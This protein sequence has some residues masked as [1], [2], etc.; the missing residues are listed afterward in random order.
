MGKLNLSTWGKRIA[1]QGGIVV[2]FIMAFEV[3][4]MI[5][6]F[7]FFFYSVFNP[8]FEWLNT[9]AVTRWMT[10]FFLPHMIL[11]PSPPLK[12]IRILGSLFFL[13]GS[14]T[15]FICA[16]QVY[17]GKIF[18]WGIAQKG[19]YR[20]IRHPQYTALGMWGIGMAILWPRFI[21]LVTL[22]IMFILYYFLAKDEE[23]RMIH[24]FGNAY[25]DYMKKTGMFLP[26]WRNNPPSFQ[27]PAPQG[28]NLLILS[29][30]VLA[31][32][33]SGF[34]LRQFT[35][36]S[37]PIASYNNMTLVSIL[38]EDKQSEETILTVSQQS[39][40]PFLQENKSY[41]GYVMPVD[42]IMQGMIANTGAEH[43]LYKQ[44]HTFQLIT[45][46]VLHPFDHL[47]RSPAA[48]MAKMKHMSPEMA[49]RHHCPLGIHN[50]TM[51][52]RACAYRRVIFV[53]VTSEE[54]KLVSGKAVF[55]LNTRKIPVRY[56]DLNIRTGEIV[57]AHAVGSKSAWQDVPTP[58]I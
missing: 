56:I 4:I 13:L 39:T 6:P 51:D 31:I 53:E 15:F 25:R 2:F 32:L 22:S 33:F 27:S 35:L 40:I 46:W 8:F 49:R 1:A 10:H 11:P 12:V 44:H 48:H 57:T 29:A 21:V 9:Y 52:C 5:S 14:T 28:N 41:L 16:L 37:L 3:M 47:R 23:K 17:L 58:E 38:P 50:A 34:L 54:Q 19:L 7:A 42:Y 55:G 30:V 26:R 24:Q 18:K 20:Y 43:H 36:A 45:D